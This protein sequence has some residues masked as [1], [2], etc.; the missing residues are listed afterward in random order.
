MS[1]QETIFKEC[2]HS[3]TTTVLEYHGPH[4]GRSVCSDCGKFLGW[5]MK[6]ENI[7]RQKQNAR[8]LSALV[9]IEGLSDWERHFI[10]TL[11]THKNIS[12]K[13]QTRLLELEEKYLTRRKANGDDG[14]NGEAVPPD[15]NPPNLH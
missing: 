11:V 7:E 5:V 1:I 8:I 9:K 2:S 15:G 12:P 6:P 13:Q 4:Y 3:K 10:R 14:F